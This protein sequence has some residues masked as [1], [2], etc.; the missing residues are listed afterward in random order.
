[1]KIKKYRNLSKL[2]QKDLANIVG[3]SQSAI[4]HWESGKILPRTETILKLSKI[5]DCTV[6]ELL[7]EG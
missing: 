1:M 4:A 7:R 3:V 2:T 5:F 6:D